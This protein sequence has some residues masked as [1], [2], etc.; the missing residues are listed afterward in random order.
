MT[1]IIRSTVLTS[2]R[3]SRPQQVVAPFSIAN[4]ASSSR[5]GLDFTHPRRLPPSS[6]RPPSTA[7]TTLLDDVLVESGVVEDEPPTEGHVT[8]STSNPAP[9]PIPTPQAQTQSS[10]RTSSPASFSKTAQHTPQF[11]LSSSSS[12]SSSRG[13]ANSAPGLRWT[14]EPTTIGTGENTTHLPTHTLNI[15]S[16]RNNVVLSLTDGLGP[17][18]G[19]VSG[20]SDKTFKNSQ[21]SSYEAATQASIKMFD[22]VVEWS[23]STPSQPR[24]RVAFSGLFGVGREAISSALSGPEGQEMRSLIVRVEDRTKIKIGGVRAPKPRRL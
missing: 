20:G 24:V 17:L 16:T 13:K 22:K 4:F 7:T 15:K 6:T 2:S 18:F 19:T 21:R 11:N 12:S 8:P 14:P 10:S 9:G 23:R 1:S 3:L 5:V